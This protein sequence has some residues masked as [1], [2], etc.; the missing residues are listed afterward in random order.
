MTAFISGYTSVESIPM[1]V[2]YKSAAVSKGASWK[3]AGSIPDG[4]ISI[5]R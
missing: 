5:F 1:C 4:A 3:V 2:R